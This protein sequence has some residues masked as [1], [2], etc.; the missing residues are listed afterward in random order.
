MKFLLDEP[1]YVDDIM[2]D[3]GVIVG[4]GEGCAHDWR[5][6]EDIKRL[7]IKAGERRPLSRSMTGLDDEARKALAAAFGTEAPERDPTK[8]IPIQGTTND[9][10]LRA[11]KAPAP[12]KG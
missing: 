4:D 12:L 7:G 2:L 6:K 10:G 8:A 3:K 9:P 1:H 5:Y 11:A